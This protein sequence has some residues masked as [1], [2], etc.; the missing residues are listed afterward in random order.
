MLY[1][2]KIKRIDELLDDLENAELNEM[3]AGYKTLNDLFSGP[4]ADLEYD[5]SAKK[6]EDIRLNAINELSKLTNIDEDIINVLLEGNRDKL[7]S[8]DIL[9]AQIKM[10]DYLNISSDV[11]EKVNNYFKR[12]SLENYKVAMIAKLSNHPDDYYLYQVMAYN[13]NDDSYTVW[14]TFNT[15]TNSINNGDY[16][17]TFHDALEVVKERIRDIER[18]Q[19]KTMII[20][21]ADLL[22]FFIE[23]MKVNHL[24]LDA[25][26][27]M[28]KDDANEFMLKKI[29]DEMQMD[30]EFG[31][32]VIDFFENIDYS[33]EDLQ[34]VFNEYSLKQNEQEQADDM[35]PEI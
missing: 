26:D 31:K 19:T 8:V 17:L 7:R 12:E 29:K 14:H 20:D 35:G 27:Y 25:I 34:N 24:T 6:L 22:E 33:K 5:T 10:Q 30:R 16:G 23:N 2:E 9:T 15:S 28:Q 4:Q 21:N 18:S 11:S 13:E 3:K 1:R 32:T